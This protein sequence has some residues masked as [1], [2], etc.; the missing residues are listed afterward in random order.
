MSL[1]KQVA[2]VTGA[3]QGIGAAI[4]RKLSANG[5]TVVC[6]DID[7]EKAEAISREC[8]SN[9][10]AA[11]VNVASA[12]ACQSLV[13]QIAER[14]GEVHILVN[15]AGINRDA[16]VHKMS[17]QQ[18][19][20]VLAVDLTGVFYMVRAAAQ[21]MR[22]ARYGRI[23]NISS[24]SWLGNIGQANYSAAKA[25]VI[26]L[27]RTASKELARH[28]ITVNAVCPGFIDTDMT[29]AIPEA[30][31]RAQVERIP[32]GRP[33]SPA[34]VANMVAFLVSDDASYVT[35]EVIS[36]GGGYQV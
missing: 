21:V 30:I 15:N 26:G 16:M 32:L 33:G 17:N 6:T 19:N 35:G 1:K 36:V 27:T 34:D 23:V 2:I 20:D 28:N 22:N 9:A 25:G 3:G 11:E 14:A 13:H 12:D 4:A 29:R 7:I 24:A 18:W 8:G 5:A 31:R 10:T